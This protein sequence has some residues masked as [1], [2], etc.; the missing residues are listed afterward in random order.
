M[1]SCGKFGAWFI[2]HNQDKLRE[3]GRGGLHQ[4][5]EL[6]MEMECLYRRL[7]VL[8]VSWV[9][10]T[11]I[12]PEG[13]AL[14]LFSPLPCAGEALTL[15][16]LSSVIAIARSN[17]RRWEMPATPYTSSV[18]LSYSRDTI[19]WKKPHVRINS[20]VFKAEECTVNMGWAHS[21]NK[22]LILGSTGGEDSS[23]R[24]WG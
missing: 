7:S 10:F 15:L 4:G 5:K 22:L 3:G 19:I 8:L 20:S 12:A 18:F 11:A 21:V 14:G 9:G 1:Q 2:G 16:L 23:G 17:I 6:W 13:I 24:S